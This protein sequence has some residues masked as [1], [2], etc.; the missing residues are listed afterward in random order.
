MPVFPSKTGTPLSYHNVYNRVLQPAL[1][2]VAPDGQRIGFH[3]FRKACG[4]LL[5]HHG[6]TLK[7][8]QGWLRHSDLTTTMNVYIEQVDQGLGGA[9]E[10]DEILPA[11]ADHGL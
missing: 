11:R 8:V 1:R 2:D 10:W 4:S 6:K 3:A 9:D 7:Q 5:L